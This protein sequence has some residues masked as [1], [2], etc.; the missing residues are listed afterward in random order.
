MT[1]FAEKAVV[2][3]VSDT[4]ETTQADAYEYTQPKEK[5]WDFESHIHLI[6]KVLDFEKKPS[7]QLAEG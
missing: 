2:R 1:T 7:L 6:L 4:K 3:S 5:E